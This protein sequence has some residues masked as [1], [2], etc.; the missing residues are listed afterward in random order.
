MKISTLEKFILGLEVVLAIELC[1][2]IVLLIEFL[3]EW[4]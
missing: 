4:P 2:V 3:K 1:I